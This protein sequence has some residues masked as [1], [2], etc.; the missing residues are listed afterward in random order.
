MSSFPLWFKSL[1]RQ[2]RELRENV[3]L[4]GAF[5]LE[6]KRRGGQKNLR[7]QYNRPRGSCYKTKITNR[8]CA[9]ENLSLGCLLGLCMWDENHSDFNQPV[10][11]GRRRIYF[12][13]HTDTNRCLK[14]LWSIISIIL[15]NQNFILSRGE[16]KHMWCLIFQPLFLSEVGN[17]LE[18]RLIRIPGLLITDLTFLSIV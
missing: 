10:W 12:K 5:Y 9:S 8:L 18:W 2:L 7:N 14:L 15:G 4:C 1:R 11:A 16:I 13:L 17:N 6:S 3:E